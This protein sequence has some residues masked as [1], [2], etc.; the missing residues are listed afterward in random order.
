MGQ[1]TCGRD[2]TATTASYT[3][4]ARRHR[5]HKAPLGRE[6]P[7]VPRGSQPRII[8]PTVTSLPPMMVTSTLIR[9]VL[10]RIRNTN[11]GSRTNDFLFQHTAC[12]FGTITS[13]GCRYVVLIKKQTRLRTSIGTLRLVM[14]NANTTSRSNL[15]GREKIPIGA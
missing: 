15:V 6:R 5:L 8:A 14:N 11:L 1:G 9:H 4:S 2:P 12:G 7:R 3:R 13:C 10:L